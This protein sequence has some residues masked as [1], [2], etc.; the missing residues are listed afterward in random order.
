MLSLFE[1]YSSKPTFQVC[2]LLGLIVIELDKFPQTSNPIFFER[3]L[4]SSTLCRMNPALD[5][6]LR[7]KKEPS[8]SLFGNSKP[9]FGVLVAVP[10]EAHIEHPCLEKNL[11]RDDT[12]GWIGKGIGKFGEAF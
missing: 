6:G 8:K 5:Q 11:A 2:F 1:I 3:F 4:V 12:G 7:M 9:E 10:L